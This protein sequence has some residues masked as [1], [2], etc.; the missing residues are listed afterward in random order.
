MNWKGEEE[1]GAAAAF[2]R[3]IRVLSG[4][5]K[6][7]IGEREREEFWDLKYFVKSITHSI[8]VGI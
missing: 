6:G 5:Q 2:Y 4:R 1:N 7:K 3:V 8:Q